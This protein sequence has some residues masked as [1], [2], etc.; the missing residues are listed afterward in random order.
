MCLRVLNNLNEQYPVTGR[1]MNWFRPINVSLYRFAQGL[2]KQGLTHR[3]M[4]TFDL[5][6]SAVFKW[7]SSYASVVAMMGDDE[8]GYAAVDGMNDQGLMVNA[9]YDTPATYATAKPRLENSNISVLC[10]PQYILDCFADAKSVAEYAR[11]NTLVILDDLVPEG[12]NERELVPAHI[13]LAVSDKAGNSTIIEISKGI[14]TV[15]ESPKYQVVTNEPD[16]ETQLSILKH[17]QYLWGQTQPSIETPIYTVL[18]G[19][20]PT[21]SFDNAAFYLTLSDMAQQP[22]DVLAQTRAFMQKGAIPYQFNPKKS[23]HA[24][25]TRWT[26]M[27]DH[28]S[29]TY[30][31]INPMNMMPVWLDAI[32]TGQP[33]AKIQLITVKGSKVDNTPEL[34]GNLQRLLV[35]CQD[36]FRVNG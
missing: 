10:W 23:D 14:L 34:H 26:N 12:G 7:R 31:F 17:W 16:Y 1:N 29:K 22:A 19:Y 35:D 11:H 5:S 28:H 32:K 18:G 20:T 27:A 33:S 24:T 15:Y 13:H 2:E 25:C 21:Q 3:Q 30:Y 9:L 8:Q 36:P 4:R 6:Q